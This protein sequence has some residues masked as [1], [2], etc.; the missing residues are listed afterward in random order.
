MFGH[1]NPSSASAALGPTDEV[2]NGIGTTY[3]FKGITQQPLYNTF[4]F[5]D[6]RGSPADPNGYFDLFVYVNTPATTGQA[7]NI[8]GRVSYIY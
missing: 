3:N 7:C 5:T 4:G 2:F 6:G 1:V 8:Y